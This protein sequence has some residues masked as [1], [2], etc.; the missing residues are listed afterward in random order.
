MHRRSFHECHERRVVLQSLEELL[1]V[2]ADNTSVLD[3]EDLRVGTSQL[4]VGGNLSRGDGQVGSR[5]LDSALVGQVLDPV[6]VT[7]VTDK[8]I[9]ALLFQDASFLIQ[10]LETASL[11][12][13]KQTEEIFV[14]FVCGSP[15]N[16]GS[17]GR[18]TLVGK[19]YGWKACTDQNQ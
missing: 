19:C 5:G 18:I 3:P 7:V 1:L 13:L 9:E 11:L 6:L 4:I 10:R 8:L 2:V 12:H 15:R 17:D 16:H 14:D